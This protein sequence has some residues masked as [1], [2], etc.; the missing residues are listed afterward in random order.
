MTSILYGCPESETT[1]ILAF[2][3]PPVKSYT[4]LNSQNR[5]SD[6]AQPEE[7]QVYLV[8]IYYAMYILFKYEYNTLKYI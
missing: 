6:S 1:S 3:F 7:L 8:I 4:L 2:Q 5:N